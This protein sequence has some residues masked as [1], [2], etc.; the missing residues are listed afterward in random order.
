MNKWDKSDNNDKIVP[1]Y[2]KNTSNINNRNI[3]LEARRKQLIE[4]KLLKV[5]KTE[6]EQRIIENDLRN[7]EEREAYLKEKRKK[8]LKKQ[9][10]EVEK[11]RINKMKE[12]EEKKKKEEEEKRLLEE[13]KKR[14][15]Q[16][17]RMKEKSEL[18]I[19][20]VQKEQEKLL[21]KSQPPTPIPPSREVLEYR[22]KL[23]LE[24]VNKKK[25]LINRKRRSESAR[26]NRMEYLMKRP[27]S[28]QVER[29]SNRVLQPTK[30]FEEKKYTNEEL[31]IIESNRK[32]KNAHE[33]VIAGMFAA[34]LANGR[35]KGFTFNPIP[36]RATP[37]WRKV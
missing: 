31:D 10:E 32:N 1:S 8:Q 33:K 18:S 5:K 13:K 4:W 28:I 3:D 35:S 14:E 7:K 27:S 19:Y 22:Y 20:K 37:A 29:D 11:W 16:E 2:L 15:E 34:E 9:K 24:Q 36:M 26:S 6:E 12:D 25:E 21:L 17:K 30:A 23:S